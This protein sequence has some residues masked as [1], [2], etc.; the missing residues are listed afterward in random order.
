MNG[1]GGSPKDRVALSII[2]SVKIPS[3]QYR[4]EKIRIS[5]NV[6]SVGIGRRKRA[7]KTTL[8]RHDI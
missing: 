6:L 2:K 5:K 4:Y 1:A 8:G 3:R 7:F